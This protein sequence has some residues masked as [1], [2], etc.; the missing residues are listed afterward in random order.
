M[1]NAVVFHFSFPST[2]RTHLWQF[3][4][5]EIRYWANDYRISSLN[6]LLF[7]RHKKIY[8]ILKTCLTHE[9]RTNRKLKI[10]GIY[11]SKQFYFIYKSIRVIWILV[12]LIQT[13][14]FFF[15]NSVNS[16]NSLLLFRIQF[17]STISFSTD[18]L[19]KF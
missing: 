8:K 9:I 2:N 7:I 15:S 18:N 13:E 3:F 14:I 5:R 1:S 11:Y 10:D 12:R 19:I 6:C 4:Q 17:L 16:V